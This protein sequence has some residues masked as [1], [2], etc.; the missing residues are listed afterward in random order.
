ML[1]TR[2][3]LNVERRTSA[4]ETVKSGGR[5]INE[6]LQGESVRRLQ[7]CWCDSTFPEGNVS[8]SAALVLFLSSDGGGDKRVFVSQPLSLSHSCV[9]RHQLTALR[10][11]LRVKVEV[12]PGLWW[13]GVLDRLVLAG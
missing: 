4:L 8:A 11:R 2:Q 13:L 10:D 9:L 5:G 6:V 12:R 7:T 1:T 3:C